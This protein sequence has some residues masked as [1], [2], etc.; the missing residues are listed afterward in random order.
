V[1]YWQERGD[2]TT[3][4]NTKFIQHVKRQWARFTSTLQHDT[5][6]KRIPADWQPSDD[7]FDILKLAMIDADF[8]RRLVP[9]F[10]LYWKESNQ[11]YSSWNTKFLQHVKYCWAN[12]HLRVSHE[13]QQNTAGT[14]SPATSSF[15][16]KHTDRSW[17]DGL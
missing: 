14:N 17:A 12:Q 5:E 4:W 2:T 16:A 3:T 1:L 13:G 15:V 10:V 6:P 9:E 11:L 8:A 7:V